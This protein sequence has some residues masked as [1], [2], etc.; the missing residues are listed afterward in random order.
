MKQTV[1]NI[2]RAIRRKFILRVSS[3]DGALVSGRSLK[4]LSTKFGF[5]RGTP[6]DRYWIEKFLAA[7]SKDIHGW[8]LEITDNYYTKIFGA[9]AVTKS[10]VLDIN[11]K[12]KQAT[13]YGDLRSLKKTI[14][15][16]TYDCII[17]THVLGMIDEYEMAVSEIHRILKPGGVLLLTSA[18]MGPVFDQE[19]N[20]W[21]FTSSGARHLFTKYFGKNVHVQTYGNVLA[22][23]AFWVGMA[24]EELT[25][26]ELDFND[27][28]YPCIVTVKA[29]KK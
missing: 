4:P 21:R 7:N 2:M 3:F 22:G 29:V 18:T 28:R 16:N 12:N 1:T 26:Q 19:T 24:Q 23:Q 27:P 11:R 9:G 13:I 6:I 14:T 15:T 5:D 8:V 25:R 17:L 20:F 10:E